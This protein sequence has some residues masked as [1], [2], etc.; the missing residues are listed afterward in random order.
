MT[1][2]PPE[3]AARLLEHLFSP[4]RTVEERGPL[5][6]KTTLYSVLDLMPDDTIIAVEVDGYWHAWNGS[7]VITRPAGGPAV[8]KLELGELLR[9]DGARFERLP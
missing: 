4:G 7:A 6:S 2:I 1:S 9:P 3:L 5:A 8:V